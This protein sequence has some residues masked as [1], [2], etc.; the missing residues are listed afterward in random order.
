MR[1]N[2]KMSNLLSGIAHT[3]S[4]S[5]SLQRLLAQGF[6]KKQE[7]YLISTLKRRGDNV[8][9]S[10]CFDKTG[11]ECF[12]NSIHIVDYQQPADLSVS[13][14]FAG[15]LFNAWTVTG[16]KETLRVI[17]SYKTEDPVVK[18]HVARDGENLLG[19]DIEGF[20]SA[21]LEIDS[22]DP[23]IPGMAEFA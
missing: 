4:L 20:E 8:T 7:C 18:W 5:D 3:T 19:D 10:D 15:A 14:A 22:T 1:R 12:V 11:Y 9:V 17:V 16:I 2:E 6:V 13:V 23:R 21:V